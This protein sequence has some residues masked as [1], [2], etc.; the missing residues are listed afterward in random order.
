MESNS[1]IRIRNTARDKKGHFVM[2]KD[3]ITEEDMPT[4]CATKMQRQNTWR[5]NWQTSKQ[6]HPHS[7]SEILLSRSQRLKELYQHIRAG[8][9]NTLTQLIF[10][11]H[12][13]NKCGIHILSWF[14]QLW[15]LGFLLKGKRPA[16]APCVRHTT[17]P[18]W[19]PVNHLV[20]QSGLAGRWWS[21]HW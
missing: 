17:G 5:K 2:I 14:W 3:S 10:I 19:L 6:T 11:K 16:L 21:A 8:L 13:S 9:S 20:F 18:S 15:A 7:Q 12:Y 1:D 4:T